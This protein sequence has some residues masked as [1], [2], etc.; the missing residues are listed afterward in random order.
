MIIKYLLH[1]SPIKDKLDDNLNPNVRAIAFNCF[2]NLG[3]LKIGSFKDFII[4]I[5][6]DNKKN[7]Q[8][9]VLE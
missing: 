2:E 5:D 6:E 7:F 1:L 8:S 9:W 4:K 3:T